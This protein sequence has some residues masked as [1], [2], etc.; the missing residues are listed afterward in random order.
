M[1]NLF[2]V[3]QIIWPICLAVLNLFFFLNL[4]YL[5]TADRAS[6]PWHEEFLIL[7]QMINEHK[8]LYCNQC[9]G[10]EFGFGEFFRFS[11]RSGLWSW[12]VQFMQKNR[13]GNIKLATHI[14]L[15]VFNVQCSGCECFVSNTRFHKPRHQHRHRK[16][17][18]FTLA[19]CIWHEHTFMRLYQIILNSIF[20]V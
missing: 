12:S 9:T 3:E 14:L 17:F 7:N 5:C 18:N 4:L 2:I 11:I 13:N 8:E 20:N 19:F 1:E 6:Q 16:L 15:F 10:M